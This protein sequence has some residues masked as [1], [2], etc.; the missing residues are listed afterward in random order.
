MEELNKYDGMDIDAH[1][2]GEANGQDESSLRH[3]Q[4]EHSN[5]GQQT[6]QALIK[7]NTVQTA[8][9]KPS[10]QK[11]KESI[12]EKERKKRPSEGGGEPG[13]KARKLTNSNK[14]YNDAKRAKKALRKV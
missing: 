1:I 3:E 11:T 13:K 12:T 8:S 7:V 4:Q 6:P 9:P 10:D 14:G 5:A 2:S